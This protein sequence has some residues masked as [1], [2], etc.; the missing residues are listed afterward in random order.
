MPLQRLATRFRNLVVF[1][2]VF[3]AAISAQSFIQQGGDLPAPESAGGSPPVATS[4][5]GNVAVVGAPGQGAWVFTRH[6][7]AWDQGTKLI[8]TGATPNTEQQ[9]AAVA[10]SADA[11]TILIGDP[12]DENN[13]ELHVGAVWA[14]AKVNGVWMQQGSKLSGTGPAALTPIYQG[15]SV[16]LSADGNTAVIGALNHYALKVNGLLV[17]FTRSNGVWTQQGNPLLG[18]GA[19]S[20]S[21][22]GPQPGEAVAVSSDGNTALLGVSSD[23]PD[24]ED[25]Y[26]AGAAWVFTRANGVWKQQGSKLVGTG[27]VSNGAGQGT[28]VALSA[29]GNTALI[30]GPVDG[31]SNYPGVNQ[32]GAAWVFSRSNGVWSQLGQKL[33]PS[34][35]SGV[36]LEGFG[37]SLSLSADGHTAAIAD[38]LGET[39]NSQGAKVVADFWVF[40]FKDGAW[41]QIGGPLVAK[42]GSPQQGTPGGAI[43]IS[44][45]SGTILLGDPDVNG[46][47]VFVAPVLGLVI[48]D[49]GNFMRGENRA[50]YTLI[51][52]NKGPVATNGGTVGLY[53]AVS[54]LVATG[55]SGSGWSCSLSALRCI[56]SD[57]IV[58]GASYPPITVT[59]NVPSNAPS[60]VQDYATTDG[61]GAGRTFASDPTVVH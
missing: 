3:S 32:T 59:V 50:T 14:F 33:T 19:D 60:T 7:G 31:Q 48:T 40:T 56:R 51:V 30:G 57:T 4:A 22:S 18:T 17:T 61:G 43:A 37:E 58:P 42:D 13:S 24:T 52:S 39:S 21:S 45:D 35:P 29:D 10:I 1:T 16:A 41:G 28:S 11:T 15:G 34:L 2:V 49:S 25:S 53:D 44:A 8:G 47:F 5:D 27:V 46:A 20:P 38:T 54:N 36:T 23:A 55:I 12:G 6:N 26:S 9:G